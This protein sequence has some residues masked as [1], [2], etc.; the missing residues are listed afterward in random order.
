MT[1]R[2]VPRPPGGGR[3]AR[4]YL[5]GEAG[6]FY[7]GHYS[8]LGAFERKLHEVR[9]RFGQEERAR[10]ARALRPTSARA[11]ERLDRFAAEG[12][13]VVT[14][15]QQAGFLTGP[16]YTIH[17]AL[18]VV[19]LAEALE[20]ALGVLV[21]PV[22]W[23]ASDDHDWAEVNHADLLVD[24]E[25]RRLELPSGDPRALPMSRRLL[26]TGTESTLDAATE[27][28][29]YQGDTPRWMKQIIRHYA[30]GT[31]VADAFE[32]V[33]AEL[34]APFDLLLT[35][36]ADAEVKRG[37]AAV[38][39]RDIAGAE[40]H[41]RLL[42]ERGAALRERGFA[43]QVTLLASATNVFGMVEG[44]RERLYR[45]GDAVAVQ[46]RGRARPLAE[47]LEELERSPAEFSPN[48]L[49]RPVVE[50]AV[51]PTLAY[52]GGPAEI[53][54]FAQLGVLFP[55]YGM[56]SPV[57]VPR[58]SATLVEPKVARDLERLGLT[59]EEVER[60]RHELVEAVARRAMP[61]EVAAA[62]AELGEGIAT[63][64]QGAMAAAERVDPTLGAALAALRNES[65]ARVGKGERKVLRALKRKETEAVARIDA[66]LAALH[67]GGA[68][69]ERVLNVLP[70]LARDPGLLQRI[71][72]T[73]SM[74]LR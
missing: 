37:A 73:I 45:R 1:T 51:F 5:A 18:T 53:A 40:R 16:L 58:F 48:V 71:Y 12:G 25:V 7:T 66:V 34:L 35:D 9:S 59:L 70:F 42:R 21:L 56:M 28:L 2:V 30:A 49:L 47:V 24:G 39:Q 44:E 41:E 8:D 15:G 72:E 22:F 11:K 17:K 31:T 29:R 57:V 27:A 38:L 33:M 10:A 36:A 62:L 52:V 67:P 23:T 69:Q 20:A 68:P 65:L 14:S 50:S 61:A 46:G 63:G 3:L 13:V 74:E 64:Y 19:R 4:A 26:E 32:G 6:A 60:P 43:E 55:E 54:Y